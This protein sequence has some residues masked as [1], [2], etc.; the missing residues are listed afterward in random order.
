MSDIEIVPVEIV[1]K[2][3]NVY[4]IARLELSIIKSLKLW[5]FSISYVTELCCTEMG[6]FA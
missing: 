4:F 3:R 5:S 6:E 2:K 1:A